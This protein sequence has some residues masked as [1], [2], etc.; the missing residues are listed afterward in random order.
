M[1]EKKS[2]RRVRYTK[3]V[4]R[5]SLL[6]LLEKKSI[7]AVTITELC[8]KADINRNTFYAHYQS[9]EEMLRIIET[10][11]LQEFINKVENSL[12]ADEYNDLMYKLCLYIE[13]NRDICEVIISCRGN[14]GDFLKRLNDTFR[15]RTVAKW[16][17]LSAKDISEMES[18]YTFIAG[19]SAA[20]IK[21]WID[22][23]FQ[24]GPETVSERIKK[25]LLS[26][27]REWIGRTHL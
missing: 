4:L 10:D 20:L 14:G 27:N 25:L 7:N 16:R 21:E 8:R 22:S 26:L 2:D 6:E 23:D 13:K 24:E 19:G 5:E 9:P 11:F 15:D 3:M 1:V 12:A 18:L 17:K